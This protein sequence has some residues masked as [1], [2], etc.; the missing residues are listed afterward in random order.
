M[1]SSWVTGEWQNCSKP[2]GKTGMQIRSVS[3]VQPL[4]DNTTRSIHNK[5]CNDDRPESRRPCNRHSCPTQWRVGQWSQ[6]HR[7]NMGVLKNRKQCLIKKGFCRET[8]NSVAQQLL[9]LSEIHCFKY[10][11]T[12]S[13]LC[14]WQ[15]WQ[16]S[17]KQIIFTG[18]TYCNTQIMFKK[19]AVKLMCLRFFC[20]ALHFMTFLVHIYKNTFYNMLVCVYY[21]YLQ[22]S[23]TCGNGTQQRQALCHTRD[24]TIGLCLDS[25]PDTIRVCRMDPCPSEC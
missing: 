5:Y 4:D 1:F 25:K 8:L 22:C 18:T 6:V 17:E 3:C 9:F 11:K 13:E 19:T 7:L 23:V 15:V 24:N 20:T 21:L 16:A 10:H 14:S 2:C 12:S